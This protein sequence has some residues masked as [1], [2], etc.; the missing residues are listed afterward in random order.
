MIDDSL[1][2]VLYTGTAQ[3]TGLENIGQER[4]DLSSTVPR[5]VYSL[6]STRL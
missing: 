6:F 1:T 5:V 4:A 3:A 2:S